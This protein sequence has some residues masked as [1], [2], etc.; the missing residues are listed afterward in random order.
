MVTH[1]WER[2][3]QELSIVIIHDSPYHR[4]ISGQLR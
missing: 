2:L 4:G 3:Q 1:G